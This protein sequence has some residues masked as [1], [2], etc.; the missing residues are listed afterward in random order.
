MNGDVSQGGSGVINRLAR[1]VKQ[2][3]SNS[4]ESGVAREEEKE[5]DQPL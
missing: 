5:E 3:M 4:Q 1:S 2:S